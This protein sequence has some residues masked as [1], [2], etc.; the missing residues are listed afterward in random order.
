MKLKRFLLFGLL[1][2]VGLAMAQGDSH[3]STADTKAPSKKSKSDVTVQG[4]ITIVNGDYVLSQ[5][6]PGNA[7]V[8]E[9]ANHKVKLEGHLGQQAEVT[10]WKRPTLGTSSD[11]LNRFGAPAP[12]TIMVT[13][14]QTLGRECGEPFEFTAS[15]ESGARLEVS[16]VP[17]GADIEIDGRFVG[18]TTSVVGIAPGQHRLLVKKQDYKPW[19]KDIEVTSGQVKVNAE[20]VKESK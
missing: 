5:F 7:Y 13:G 8:L 6:D 2:A 9:R 14:I 3:Q 19:E 18:Q 17:A 4:C 1:F 10:G 11:S 20:L 15:P 16:S 12:V